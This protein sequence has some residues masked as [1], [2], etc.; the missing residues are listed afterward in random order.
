MVLGA[1]TL[2]ILAVV[3]YGAFRWARHHGQT[4]GLLAW[5]VAQGTAVV[6]GLAVLVYQKPGSFYTNFVIFPSLIL[7]LSGLLGTIVAVLLGLTALIK[8][9]DAHRAL[10]GISVSLLSAAIATAL[11]VWRAS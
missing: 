5:R 11:I 6:F 4:I 1:L 2:G 9:D 3:G 8:R 10:K 7:Y